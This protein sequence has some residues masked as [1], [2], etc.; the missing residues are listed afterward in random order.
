[1]HQD[2]IPKYT[3]SDF[4]QPCGLTPCYTLFELSGLVRLVRR[5][6][7]DPYSNPSTTPHSVVVPC[8]FLSFPA[9]GGS[10]KPKVASAKHLQSSP[11]SA[12]RNETSVRVAGCATCGPNP[13]RKFPEP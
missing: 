12:E 10:L 5:G 9:Q 2:D 3:E 11:H 6:G 4:C 13:C 8:L 7:L 1:M